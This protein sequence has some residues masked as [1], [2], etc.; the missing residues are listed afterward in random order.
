MLAFVMLGSSIDCVNSMKNCGNTVS[1]ALR[2]EN[3]VEHVF[4]D[5]APRHV[6][7]YGHDLNVPSLVEGLDTVGFDATEL[8]N[9]AVPKVRFMKRYELKV[10][11]MMW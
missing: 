5:F 4:V 6:H 7:V 10:E 3:G 2:S 11:G 8:K 1:Q 9:L